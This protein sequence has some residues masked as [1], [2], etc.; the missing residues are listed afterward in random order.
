[1]KLFAI[2]ASATLLLVVS[3]AHA[4]TRNRQPA[5]PRRN[6][7][8]AATPSPTPATPTPTPAV[9]QQVFP[10]TP[11][12]VVNGQTITTAEFEPELRQGIDSVEQRVREA[13][14]NILELQINTMLLAAEAKKR[15]I[16]THQLYENEVSKKIPAPTEAQIKKVMDDNREQFAGADQ[17]T[18]RPQIVAFLHDEAE[19]KLADDLAN[20]L[21]KTNPV[22]MGVDINSPS[23]NNSSVV[24]TV[25][26]V[27][28]V[29][30]T[31]VERLKP[32]VY[33]L[34]F[35]AWDAAHK[36]AD[37]IIDDNLLLAEANKQH[38]GPEEIIRKEVS[39]KVRPPTEADVA[40]FY[41]ENKS[42][43]G[44]DLNS[45]HTQLVNY[46]QDEARQKLERDLSQRLRKSSDIKWLINEPPQPVQLISVDDDPARGDVNAAI[47]VVEFTDFQCPAC[48]AMQP[49]LEEVLKS[50]GNKIRFV[51]RDFPL[52]QHENAFKAAQAADAANAQGKFFEYTSLL[53]KRQN[54]L[55]VASLKKY[56]TEL[57]LDRAKFDAALDKETYAAEVKHDM[58]D[59]EIYGISSTP[60]IFVNGVMLKTLSA[61][62][63]REAIDRATAA[64]KSPAP[65][66]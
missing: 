31:L 46:L 20:R 10:P 35:E 1:M 36:R 28:L 55:D 19:N 33:K 39:E 21:R 63:L 65:A 52:G 16:T 29:A 14:N 22:V 17:A 32:V 50:Y 45:M 15:G 41:S 64:A 8:I 62:G 60:T 42:R 13:R 11:V 49:V 57:G 23:L 7:A 43:I 61:D 51:V 3:L 37:Q 66:Q 38:V 5:P 48:A 18:A 34:R 59:G 27:P 58:D 54:A 40:K 2:T 26:G 25:G 4:Q 47:T 56:A 9:S 53:F 30:S 6:P 24:A 44:G 12:V